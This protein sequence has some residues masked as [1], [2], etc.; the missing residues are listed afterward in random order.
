[1]GYIQHNGC[2]MMRME[3][4][5]ADMSDHGIIDDRDVEVFGSLQLGVPKAPDI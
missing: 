4:L 5:H 2:K 3:V 1:M